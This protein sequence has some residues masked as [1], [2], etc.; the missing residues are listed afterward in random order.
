MAD[1]LQLRVWLTEAEAARHALAMGQAVAEV[2]RD[3]RR[4]TFTKADVTRLSDYIEELE[5][6]IAKAEDAV[7][8]TTLT[9]R[10]AIALR[11]QN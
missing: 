2:W 9:R 11:Y 10:R 3:G 5:R 4:M 7:N 6:K 8:G 1:L